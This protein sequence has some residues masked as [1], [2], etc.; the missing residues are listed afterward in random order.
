MIRLLIVLAVV[1]VLAFYMN[2]A[3]RDPAGGAAQPP[4]VRYERDTQEAQAL[5]TE[6]QEQARQQL[7]AIDAASD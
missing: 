2:R 4:E 5:E 1:V 3:S 6:L 7:D